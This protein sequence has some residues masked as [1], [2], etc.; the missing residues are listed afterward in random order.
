MFLSMNIIENYNHLNIHPIQKMRLYAQGR[1]LLSL[2]R[3]QQRGIQP[4]DIPNF[5]RLID[6]E[7]QDAFIAVDC[8]GWYFSNPARPCT[9]IEIHPE[10]LQFWQTVRFEYDYLTWHP[11]YLDEIPVLAYYSSYFK[12][13][14]LDDFLKFCQEWSLFHQKMIIG[15][16]PTKIKY[17]YLSKNLLEMIQKVIH[18]SAAVRVLDQSDFDLLF[19]IEK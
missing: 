4:V 19:V 1:P 16:D 7:L 14:R 5:V 8:A 12:Y 9:A 11:T 6:R 13:S 3:R 15:L 10:S 17:N 2:W 18:P